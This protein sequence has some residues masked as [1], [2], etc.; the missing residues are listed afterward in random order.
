LLPTQA[1]KQQT[2][3]QDIMN[4]FIRP[5]MDMVMFFN[6]VTGQRFSVQENIICDYHLS[7]DDS[8]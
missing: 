3:K 1:V 7:L 6:T 8:S 2:V 4:I 5:K